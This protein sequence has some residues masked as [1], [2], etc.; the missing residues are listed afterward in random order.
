MRVCAEETG[1]DKSVPPGSERERGR[2]RAGW[3]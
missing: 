1:A 2:E 3:H